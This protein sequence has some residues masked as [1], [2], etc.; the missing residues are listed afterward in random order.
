V[1]NLH[2]LE[3]WLADTVL[4]KEDKNKAKPYFFV[5]GGNNGKG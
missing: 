2:S 4:K 5:L 1:Q 3:V